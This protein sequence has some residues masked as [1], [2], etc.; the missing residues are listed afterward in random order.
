MTATDAGQSD[1]PAGSGRLRRAALWAGPVGVVVSALGIFLPVLLAPWFSWTGNAL[2]HLGRAGEATAP[3]FNGGLVVAG[4]LGLAFAARVW[5]AAENTLGRLGVVLLALSFAN[6]A[7]VGVFA[8]PHDLHG[9]V[10][11]AF[12]LS[13]T[14]GLFVHGSG[15]AL[16]GHRRRGLLSIWLGIA[17]ITGWLLFAAAPFDGIALPEL[18]GSAALATWVLVTF[19]ALGA[20]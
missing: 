4:L 5:L 11:V 6:M 18:V 12:F 1:A 10:A 13:F 15:D 17:H 8:L 9:P 3:L 7:L 16:A 20:R 19:R 14:Y 2:S